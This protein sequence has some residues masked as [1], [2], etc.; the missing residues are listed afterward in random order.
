MD[1]ESGRILEIGLDTTIQAK[2][3]VMYTLYYK[4][5]T[6]LLKKVSLEKGSWNIK[7]AYFDQIF[8]ADAD[9]TI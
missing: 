3:T 6:V 9:T 8:E 4:M 2:T 1:K 7:G 5:S